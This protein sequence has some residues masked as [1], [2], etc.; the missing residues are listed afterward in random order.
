MKTTLSVTS[1]SLKLTT[2]CGTCGAL[3]TFKSNDLA[4]ID[5]RRWPTECESCR[6]PSARVVPKKR[7]GKR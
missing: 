2:N 5:G 1:M 6:V 3:F 7:R 4:D